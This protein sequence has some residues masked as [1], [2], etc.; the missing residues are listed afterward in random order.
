MAAY[1]KNGSG[2]LPFIQKEEVTSPFTDIV[3]RAKVDA[4]LKTV[5]GVERIHVNSLN[6]LPKEQGPNGERV[7]EPDN[8]D[9]RVRFFGNVNTVF[10]AF[11][12]CPYLV[13]TTG[14]FEVTFYG[15]GLNILTISDSAARSID[16]WLDG[17]SQ[18]TLSISGTSDVIANRNTKSSQII[19]LAKGLSLGWHTIKAVRNAT[20]SYF[21]G[22]EIVNESAQMTVKAGKAHGNG[23]E[24]DLASDQ[25][26]DYNL[27]FDNV[28]DINVGTRGGRVITY[29]DPVD[30]TVKKR[31]TKTDA[32][33]L[34][35]GSADHTN[36]T[37]YRIINFREFGRE[38]GDDISTLTTSRSDRA[39]T[40]DDGTTTLVGNDVIIDGGAG[41]GG[42]YVD[43]STGFIT[44]TFVGT[45]LDVDIDAS[46]A[47][48]T[49]TF[50]VD[51]SS[52]GTKTT[53][54][55]F[56]R[57][58]YKIVSGLPYGT[59]TVKITTTS[60]SDNYYNFIVYQP[61]KP[62][63][64]EGAIELADY[65][66]MADYV[67]ADTSG[68]DSAL[69]LSDG[70]L[71]KHA[72]REFIYT[73]TWSVV[74]DLNVRGGFTVQS[75][76]TNDYIE[77][78]FFGTG[79][80]I[81]GFGS[82]GAVSAQLS[83]DGA[84]Y[85]GAATNRDGDGGASGSWTSGTSTWSTPT[86][87]GSRLQVSGLSL[88]IHTIK[89]EIIAGA[90]NTLNIVSLDIITPINSAHTTFGSLSMKDIRNF[91]SMKDVNKI[92][93]QDSTKVYCHANFYAAGANASSIFKSKNIS[94]ILKP[95]V[96][97]HIFYFEEPMI[98]NRYVAMIHG[99]SRAE[100]GRVGSTYIDHIRY[101]GR[102][103]AYFQGST[104]GAVYTVVADDTLNSTLEI[105]GKLEKDELEE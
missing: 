5:F 20:N 61:K 19:N 62:T 72:T 49:T 105:K 23:Y 70:V 56:E 43:V 69:K 96:G 34:N 81:G 18:G 37:P 42:M 1:K 73:G 44:I 52:I 16:W 53:P 26:I 90:A 28:A 40:L 63:L 30:G 97:N 76:T 83:I 65:N 48:G 71:R 29:L 55:A 17:A 66:V 64:P 74:L 92:V 88:G 35:L 102:F 11:G 57:T 10:G 13:D 6:L 4:S 77:Y 86:G 85:T 101:N 27:G 100:S 15:T 7:Y 91:D 21:F 87:Y 41:Y 24:Y 89:L 25:L 38:R 59:H 46:G 67:N 45:G 14:G 31:L 54:A 95:T 104:N 99:E 60:N 32:S 39:F 98:D 84:L 79:I 78:T 3:N 75:T 80:E 12:L 8:G 51:G 93:D 68:T 2:Y 103:Q 36:E 9:A 58:R 82:G 94:Q 22:F 50:S 33:Q 47:R